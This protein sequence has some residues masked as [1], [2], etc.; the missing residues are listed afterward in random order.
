MWDDL[1]SRCPGL[2]IDN[3]A[4][5]GR[6]IDIETMSRSIPLWRSDLQCY[7]GYSGAS[8]QNQTYGLG[9]WTPLNVGFCDRE[10]TYMFRSA[11]GPGLD[12]AMAEFEKDAK[13]HFSIEWLRTMLGELNQ[14]RDLFLGDFYP[15]AAYSFSEDAWAAWQ[16]DRPD[17]KSGVVLAFRRARSPFGDAT[18]ALHGLD[19]AT[20][21]EFRDLDGGKVV[22]MSGKDCMEKGLPIA[23]GVKP[24][25]R[26]FIYK[27]SR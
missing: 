9:L 20:E 19:P 26:A 8:M 1:L 14:V 3:C 27:A 10:D 15:L 13:N 17:L 18:F 11:L 24:G 5:G 12:L 25:S 22:K 21:Y 23:I 6:R 16:F 4:S 7:P 2:L